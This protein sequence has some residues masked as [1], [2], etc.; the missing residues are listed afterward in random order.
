MATKKTGARRAR[1]T[2]TTQRLLD[3]RPDTAD[4]R[5]RMFEPTLVDVPSEMPLARFTKLGVPVLD[6][7]EEGACTAYG[8]ATV[9]HTLLRRRQ[10]DAV[11]GRVSTRML[12]DMARRYDEWE[13]E[14]YDGSS[15]RGA[16]KGWHRHGVCAEECWPDTPG[17]PLHEVYTEERARAA[18]EH[19]L[20]AY[21]RVN[22]KDLVAMHA[23]FA[24]VGVLYASAAVHADWL[25]PPSNG[26]IEWSEQPVAGYH[27]F[28]IVGYDRDGFWIQNSWG[29]RWGKRGYGWISYD[30]WLQRG[31]DVWVARLAVPVRLQRVEA[32][33]TSNSFLARQAN[34]YSQA[35]LRPHI[36]SLGN[37]G[38]LRTTGRFGTGQDDVRNLI[39]QDLPRITRD[40][41]KKR[42]MLY[43]HGG[44]VP[45]QAAIQRVADLRELML[46]RQ[47]YPLCFVWKTDFWSTLGNV[48]RDAVRPRSEGLMDKAKGV[49][50]DRVDDTIEPLARALGG[51]AMW[52]EMKEN[53]LLA[54]TAVVRNGDQLTEAGGAAQVARLLG[55]WMLADPD[56]ELHLVGHSAGSILLAPLAQLLTADGLVSSGPAASMQGIGQRIASLN[57][58][59][60]AMTMAL[61][62]QSYAPALASRKIDRAALF[63]LTDRAEQDDHCA[64][65]YNKSLLYLVAHAFEARAR[66]WVR[67]EHR[68][69]TPLLG[70]ARFIESNGAIRDLLAIGKLDWIQAPVQGEPANAADGS[71]ATTH[72]GFDDD[73]ATLQATL[74]RILGER[75]TAV[76]VRIHR[77]ESGLDDCRARLSEALAPVG[78]RG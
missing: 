10:P 51:K 42:V 26:V 55:E 73:A 40:W 46:P 47:V 35:D 3:A 13:G 38:R 12:Y 45:E 15:C 53:A 69:G 68:N 77:S 33:S 20:G 18:Q 78:G 6:Q 71:A 43:A 52:D 17:R 14:D 56:V 57:L 29:T 1:A 9:A 31:T 27:A 76:P 62:E 49:L 5:D 41:P 37:D 21:Y 32:V 72:G 74:C 30:E 23:A 24:E 67:R 59:A 16:M 36:V 8:L 7:G 28:A 34:S 66:S 61:F 58:W 60:P 19:P 4:F 39:R 48:L 50:L 63:T 22:H 75:S 54:T 11:T 64:R 70:M 44:L 25:A 2:A 65:V